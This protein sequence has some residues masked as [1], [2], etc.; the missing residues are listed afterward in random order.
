MHLNI[1]R[2]SKTYS[3]QKNVIYNL[4]ISFYF[5]HKI[6]HLINANLMEG[7]LTENNILVLL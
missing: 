1:V 5:V 6:N 7:C 3:I 4:L 2:Y